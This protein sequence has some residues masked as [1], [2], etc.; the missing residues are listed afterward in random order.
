MV[1][2]RPIMAGFGVA[3]FW[4][5]ATDSRK[6]EKTGATMVADHPAIWAAAGDAI[7]RCVGMWAR[8]VSP[9]D[10]ALPG[11]DRSYRGNDLFVDMVPQSSWAANARSLLTPTQWKRLSLMVRTRVDG[12][13]SCGARATPKAPLEAHERWEFKINGEQCLRRMVALCKKCH[14]S[15]HYGLAETQGLGWTAKQHLMRVTG[16]SEENANIHIRN[17]FILWQERS[18]K[19]WKLDIQIIQRAGFAVARAGNALS[20]CVGR[21]EAVDGACIA[22]FR[23]LDEIMTWSSLPDQK[24]RELMALDLPLRAMTGDFGE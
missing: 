7:A 9:S 2:D 3:Y 14:R 18:Q 16:L 1:A 22:C 5:P 24:K 13:E 12:C 17:A 23:S 20:P 21:C 6:A 8:V 4:V 19:T 10:M 15:T 11:E